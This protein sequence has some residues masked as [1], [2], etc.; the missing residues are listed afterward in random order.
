M[1]RVVVVGGGLGGLS[2]GVLLAKNGYEVCVLEQGVQ[3]GGCLQCFYRRGVKFET[4]MH[5]IGSA[6]EGQILNKMLRYLE[7]ADK[8]S[9]SRL[10]TAR[11]HTV[12]LGGERFDF[13]NGKEPFIEQMARLIHSA[14]YDEVIVECHQRISFGQ[15]L[16]PVVQPHHPEVV[17]QLAQRHVDG[18][19]HP[20]D[21]QHADGA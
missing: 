6:D 3:I 4:G 10:D 14:A 1:K 11:Y 9:L 19:F 5:F 21:V 15:C 18:V 17:Q 20:V 13:A 8:I 7:I 12:A 2:T 16:L